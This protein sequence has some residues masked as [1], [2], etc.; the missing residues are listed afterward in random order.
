MTAMGLRSDPRAATPEPPPPSR[1]RGRRPLR[2]SSIDVLTGEA[3]A[4]SDG[5]GGGGASRQARMARWAA[6]LR[7]EGQFAGEAL[8]D[9]IERAALALDTSV[10][11]AA[12]EQARP[13][14]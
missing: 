9:G 4:G 3:D 14:R 7:L 13:E 5:G 11:I 10:G 12:A 1:S 2:G 6:G 8:T